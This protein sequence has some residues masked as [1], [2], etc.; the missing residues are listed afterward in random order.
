MRDRFVVRAPI[1][2]VW[3]FLMD[4]HRVVLCMPG[5]HLEQIESDRAYLGSV[6]MAVGPFITSYKGRVQFAEV[7]ES[8]HRARLTAEGHERGGGA[9]Q[10]SMVSS[11][12]TVGEGTEVVVDVS[13]E[14]TS[15]LVHL[16][17]GLT[18]NLAQELF[19]QFVTCV[20]ERLEAPLGAPSTGETPAGSAPVQVL[21]LLAKAFLRLF[22]GSPK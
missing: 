20:K 6:K 19:G 11:L 16:G 17:L 9:A 1:D 8:L 22:H 15:R 2:D 10:G 4:P 18:Q 5:A 21:P 14:G 13:F 3:G 12:R 7:D